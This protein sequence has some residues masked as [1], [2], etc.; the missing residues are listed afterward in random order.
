[1]IIKTEKLNAG[2]DKL[3][4]LFDVD[5]F[6]KA[7]EIVA[8]I[9]PNGAG[10]STVL[11]SIFNMCNITKGKIIF[12]D[13]NITDL[14]SDELVELGISYVPQGRPVFSQLTVKENLEMGA[15]LVNDKKIVEKKLND[16][17]E[18][19]PVLKKKRS[20]NAFAL[21]GGEQQMLA[22]GRALMQ[23]PALLLLDE[24]SAG[25]SPLMMKEVFEKIKEIRDEGTAILIVEQNAK[26]AI[27]LANRTY[28]LEDGKIALEGGKDI[29]KNKMIKK[30]Y[31]GG[32]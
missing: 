26:A 27:E 7:S 10:K 3:K 2:Y 16:V 17:Y 28:V 32:R 30:I 21:S 15:Y 22:I 5:V 4:V 8:L 25:L 1:M 29:T 6:V 19:F 9:G 18:K 13:K 14:K 12:R 20:L 31:L 23:D 24:P 11:K